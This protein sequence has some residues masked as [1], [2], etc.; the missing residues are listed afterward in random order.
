MQP[1][2][3]EVQP[4]LGIPASAISVHGRIIAFAQAASQPVP[5]GALATAV[6]DLRR[7]SI[8]QLLTLE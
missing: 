2:L 7:I 5:G 4:A 3:W 1:G 8:S 6:T